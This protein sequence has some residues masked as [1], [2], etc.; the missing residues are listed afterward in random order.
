MFKPYSVLHDGHEL[1]PAKGVNNKKLT[2]VTAST[3]RQSP[4]GKVFD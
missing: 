2:H 1:N 4:N 3:L